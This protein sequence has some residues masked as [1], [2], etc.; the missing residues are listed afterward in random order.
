MRRI[1]IPV[2]LIMSIGL[3][4]G[5]QKDKDQDDHTM[6]KTMMQKMEKGQKEHKMDGKMMKNMDHDKMMENMK[7]KKGMAMMESDSEALYYTCPME[8]H[9]NIHS[10]E[11]GKCSECGMALVAVKKATAEKAEFYV[12]PMA[13]HSNTRSNEPGKCSECGMEMIPA[14][15]EK[16]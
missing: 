2:M 5:Q 14:A 6:D 16:N 15:L 9:K 1:L 3:V 8:S 7:H 11:P 4:S 12:C 13:S 10:D